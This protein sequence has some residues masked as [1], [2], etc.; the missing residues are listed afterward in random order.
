MLM[1]ICF[2]VSLHLKQKEILPGCKGELITQP[3]LPPEN[4]V[5]LIKLFTLYNRS[6]ENHLY[7]NSNMIRHYFFVVKIFMKITQGAHIYVLI[8]VGLKSLM[9]F[10]PLQ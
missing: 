7:E 10:E 9:S 5:N 6:I 3:V 1:M 2:N 4:I 8:E